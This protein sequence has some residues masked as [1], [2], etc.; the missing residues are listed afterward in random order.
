MKDI[1]HMYTF[2]FKYFFILA[3]GKKLEVVEVGGE[4]SFSVLK[5]NPKVVV[6][7]FL[8]MILTT[9]LCIYQYKASFNLI[10]PKLEV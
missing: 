5:H 7:V 3:L 10:G 2:F 4:K 8:C 1:Y 9:L 6:D